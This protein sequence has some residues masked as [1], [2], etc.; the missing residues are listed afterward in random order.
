MSDYLTGCLC[1]VF[2]MGLG[3]TAIDS[4]TKPNIS[5]T[6]LYRFCLSHNISLEDCKIP[7]RHLDKNNN[8]KEAGRVE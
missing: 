4:L 6:E 5:D 3:I 7:T 8:T 1:G 2:V